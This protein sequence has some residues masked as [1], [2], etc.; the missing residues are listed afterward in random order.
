MDNGEPIL[1]DRTKNIQGYRDSGKVMVETRVAEINALVN[2]MESETFLADVLGFPKN[3]SVD[4][5]T[6]AVMG[7]GLGGTSA[8]LAADRDHERIK[9]CCPMDASFSS[10]QDDLD[11][12]V[13]EDTPLFHLKADDYNQLDVNG[14]NQRK[15]SEKY[16]YYVK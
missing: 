7:H 1:F 16:F 9:A 15:S 11:F 4:M 13:L 10:Y 12:L 5:S 6:L 8:L 3:V 14:Y 2:E